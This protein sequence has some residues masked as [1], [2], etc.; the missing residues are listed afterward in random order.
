MAKKKRDFNQIP[1]EFSRLKPGDKMSFYTGKEDLLPIPGDVCDEL[2]TPDIINLAPDRKG[3]QEG[4]SVIY[5]PDATYNYLS[6][7]ERY[8]KSIQLAPAYIQEKSNKIV[9]GFCSHTSPTGYWEVTISTGGNATYLTFDPPFLVILCPRPFNISELTTI[10]TDSTV[11]SWS[12][13]AGNRT[14]LITPD[15]TADPQIDVQSS[16]FTNTCDSASVS[17]LILRVETDNPLVFAD[18]V[19]LNR[20]ID[21]FDGLGYSAI[22]SGIL[23]R[24]VVVVNRLPGNQQR[25][26][27]WQ[28][29]NILITWSTPACDSEFITG[30]RL[31]QLFTS[32]IDIQGFTLIQNRIAEIAVNQR[33]RIAADFA[34]YGTSTD[35]S[36][37]EPITVNYDATLPLKT[38]F[39]DDSAR[40]LGYAEIGDVTTTVEL[41]V[42]VRD[43]IE[44]PRVLG[45]AQ[46]QD[47]T[48]TVEFGVQVRDLMESTTKILG[49]VQLQDVTTTVDL[50]GVIIG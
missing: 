32:Y 7:S 20:P 45:Y 42:Q 12:Q 34:F 22:E 17:P 36:Y 19:I 3:R 50:G 28:G 6:V 29:E 40:C 11:F 41:G 14:V 21:N 24:K 15:N 2:P 10:S 48:T 8:D 9:Y 47:V 31:Q 35:V 25:A 4:T 44:L 13:I 37:S 26:F 16:C 39:A 27:I 33:Y 23:C 18:L 1:D 30:Y 43:L 49:Y 5:S 46:L 38:V